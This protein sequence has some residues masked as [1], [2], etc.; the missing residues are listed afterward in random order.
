MT[1]NEAVRVIKKNFPKTAKIVDGKYKGGFDDTGS[2]FG[3]ALLLS[4]S[5][6]EEKQKTKNMINADRVKSMGNEELADFLLKVNCAYSEPC[7][8]GQKPCKWADDPAHDKGCK[9]CFLAWLVA[10]VKE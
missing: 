2:A 8:T 5:A 3:K 4:I 1:E 6:L 10:D 7:M 9:D